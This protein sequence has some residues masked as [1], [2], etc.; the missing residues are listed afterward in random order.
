MRA[1]AEHD[2]PPA[3]GGEAVA[4]GTVVHVDPVVVVDPREVG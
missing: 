1:H 2:D 4:G 3:G